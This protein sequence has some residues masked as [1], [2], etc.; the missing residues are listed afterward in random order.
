MSRDWT[1]LPS[2][3]H[4]TLI[5]NNSQFISFH[6][7]IDSFQFSVCILFVS[8]CYL[9]RVQKNI[10]GYI[11]CTLK[12]FINLIISCIFLVI[13]RNFNTRPRSY[14]SMRIKM[15]LASL[16]HVL[17]SS[18]TSHKNEPYL[19]FHAVIPCTFFLLFLSLSLY[20]IQCNVYNV[21]CYFSSQNKFTYSFSLYFLI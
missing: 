6:P 15:F 21:S 18:H 5:F 9:F 16:P 10:L 7:F 19:H 14:M 11:S 1:E 3:I 12:V 4:L 17:Y 2:K 20:V 8:Q 13:P